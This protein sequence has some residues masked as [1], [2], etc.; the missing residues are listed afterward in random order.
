MDDHQTCRKPRSLSAWGT[1]PSPW[2]GLLACILHTTPMFLFCIVP[3]R[4]AALCSPFSSMLFFG[5]RPRSD[6]C[7]GGVDVCVLPSST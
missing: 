3:D 1:I 7:V 6:W 4:S 5:N 2:Y